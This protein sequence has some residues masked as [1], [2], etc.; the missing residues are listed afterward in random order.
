MKT[1]T[2]RAKPF[3][4]KAID[5]VLT[6]NHNPH[7]DPYYEK[8]GGGMEVDMRS[9]FEKF[10][11]QFGDWDFNHDY[12]PEMVEALKVMR[13]W[14]KP[15]IDKFWEKARRKL[16]KV[17][18][19]RKNYHVHHHEL[20]FANLAARFVIGNSLSFSYFDRDDDDLACGFQ[21]YHLQEAT[22]Q[23]LTIKQHT[24][25]HKHMQT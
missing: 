1:M 15:Q 19:V 12:R 25:L 20:S 4:I 13:F 14:I 6:Y 5:G 9:A 22:L 18:R 24:A 10:Q 17:D 23:L 3:R 8:N 21:D 11:M 7:R 2:T 16:P